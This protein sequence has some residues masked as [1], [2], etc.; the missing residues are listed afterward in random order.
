MGRREG[1]LRKMGTWAEKEKVGQKEEQTY[2]EGRRAD[3]GSSGDGKKWECRMS[4]RVCR[5]R[6]IGG[7][8]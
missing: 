5:L 1:Y 6:C 3:G 7:R 4:V 8:R 2:L